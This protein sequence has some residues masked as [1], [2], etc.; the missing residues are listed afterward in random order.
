VDETVSLRI[1]QAAAAVPDDFGAVASIA[2]RGEG[3]VTITGE[4]GTTVEVSID[5][6]FVS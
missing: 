5:W 4:N 1:V 6:G 2:P 3:G